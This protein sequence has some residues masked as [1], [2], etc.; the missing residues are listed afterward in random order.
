MKVTFNKLSKSNG[1]RRLSNN[2]VTLNNDSHNNSALVS[3]CLKVQL[4]TAHKNLKLRS[5]ISEEDYTMLSKA[6]IDTPLKPTVS[7]KPLRTLLVKGGRT[8]NITYQSICNA[9]G[10]DQY[11][12]GEEKFFNILDIEEPYSPNYFDEHTLKI[13]KKY[14]Q[15]LESDIDDAFMD[16]GV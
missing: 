6:S 10:V 1:K 16:L 2:S 15:L 4:S 8:N 3:S 5:D 7:I 14:D 13:L 12:Y 9:L 11:K